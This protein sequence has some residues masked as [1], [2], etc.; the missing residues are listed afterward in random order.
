[1]A[2]AFGKVPLE[3]AL[4][5]LGIASRSRTRQWAVEGRLKVNGRTVT[6]PAALVVPERDRFALNGNIFKP[7]ANYTVVVH[8]PKNYVTT[9]SDEK[10]RKTVY[11]LLPPGLQHLHPVGRLDMQTTGLLLLTTDTKL[12][13]FLTDP[14]NAVERVY[15]VTVKGRV[16]DEDTDKL[17]RGITDGGE[18]LKAHKIVVRK[19]SNHESHLTMTL[20]EGKNREIRR[21]CKAIGHEVTAL[22]RI[23]FGPIG[24]GNVLTGQHRHLTEQEVK[25]LR[26][27]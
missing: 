23:A 18:V 15:A 8:K 17:S 20:V 4:S 14:A 21:M 6:D 19:L 7:T 3:R 1:M 10:G 22:K 26:A 2:R 13:A 24:L 12:S 5:K 11:D 25:T 16:G 27:L 9:R